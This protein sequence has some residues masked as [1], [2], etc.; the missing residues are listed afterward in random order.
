[1]LGEVRIYDGEG[2]L[3]KIVNPF[4]DYSSKNLKGN[5]KLHKCFNFKCRKKTKRKKY[6]SDDCKKEAMQIRQQRERKERE[7]AK[8][9][10]PALFCVNKE[11][12][13]KLRLNRKKY[14]SEKCEL[15]L[16]KIKDRKKAAE[17][18]KRNEEIRNAGLHES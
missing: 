13:K 11:C 3:K 9:K 16:R 7:S 6:C 10:K 2:N 5:S 14:C 15:V 17:I 12:G 8:A 18:N 4:I 1:M